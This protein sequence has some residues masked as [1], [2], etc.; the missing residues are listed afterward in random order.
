[1]TDVLGL[2]LSLASTMLEEEGVEVVVDEVSCRKGASGD[3]ER[4]VRQQILADNRVILTYASFQTS[5]N[6]L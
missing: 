5:V 1:M 2:P 4:V 3:S 6:S